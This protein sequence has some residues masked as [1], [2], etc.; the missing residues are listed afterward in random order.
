MPNTVHT[1]GLEG[2]RQIGGSEKLVCPH[3]WQG[4]SAVHGNPDAGGCVL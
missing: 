3:D 1:G 2:C 4:S